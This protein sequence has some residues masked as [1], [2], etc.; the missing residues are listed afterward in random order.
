MA[1]LRENNV[2]NQ[3]E[4]SLE[5]HYSLTLGVAATWRAQIGEN[6]SYFDQV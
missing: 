5:I 2:V 3:N 6:R 1:R 4:H